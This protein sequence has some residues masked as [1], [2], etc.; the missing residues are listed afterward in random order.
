MVD[1]AKQLKVPALDP[2]FFVLDEDRINI[3]RLEK[4]S[5]KHPINILVTGN[6]GCGKS[7]LVRQFASYYQRPMA[8][9]Q[10]GL[11][12]EAGQLFGQQRLKE[13]ETFYQSFLFPRAIRVPGCVIHLEEINRSE[14][15]HALN[16]LFSV[17]S[18]ERS[19]WI[20]EL[21]MVDVAP[22]L[23]FFATMNEGVEFSGTDEMDAALKDR[24]YR[25]HLEY[26]PVSVEKEILVIKTGIAPS[27]A[28][29]ILNIVSRLRSNKQTPIDI[30]IRHS[31][32]IAELAAV[33]A[34]LREAV[35]YSLQISMDVLESLLLSIH[36]ETGDT[37]VEPRRYER[38]VPPNYI[39]S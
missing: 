18:E 17:L 25:V 33:G 28:S 39:P 26:P 29:D 4:L 3:D 35:I 32:M 2:N 24:F 38:Y 7:S 10:V 37:E 19:I 21:G 1:F 16:E 27:L 20:D 6:Q 22:R 11:L 23:I 9:F 14:N 12:S 36:V 30:S 31:L 34:P 8:T 15:P 5:E 13:G